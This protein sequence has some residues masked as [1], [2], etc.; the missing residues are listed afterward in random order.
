MKMKVMED[1]GILLEKEMLLDFELEQLKDQYEEAVI[2][3]NFRESRNILT[4]EFQVFQELENVREKIEEY[5]EQ[6]RV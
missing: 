6:M 2:E 3:E 4:L 1:I 5:G